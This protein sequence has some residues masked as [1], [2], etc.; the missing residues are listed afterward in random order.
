MYANFEEKQVYCNYYRVQF[1]KFL[2]SEMQ[3]KDRIF[4]YRTPSGYNQEFIKH[5]IGALLN[6]NKSVQYSKDCD[7]RP[8]QPLT[9]EVRMKFNILPNT[10]NLS[11]TPEEVSKMCPPKFRNYFRQNFKKQFYVE[12]CPS[13]DPAGFEEEYVIKIYEV[14]KTFPTMTRLQAVERT[15]ERKV[16]RVKIESY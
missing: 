12:Q 4:V 11:E 2:P 7:V 1:E 8:L 15:F 6:H 10:K 3:V 14:K 9:S 13:L 16:P 5:D